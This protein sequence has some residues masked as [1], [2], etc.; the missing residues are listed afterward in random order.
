MA[1]GKAQARKIIATNRRARYDYHLGERLEAGLQLEGWEAKSLRAG[2]VQL[3]DGHVRILR[4]EAFLLGARIQP[5]QSA[6][7]HVSADPERTRRLLLH[8]R[9][10]NHLA[11]AVMRKGQALIPTLL[12]WKDGR[13]KLEIALATGKKTHDKRAAIQERDWKRQQQRLLKQRSR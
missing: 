7:S 11:G 6:S 10:I 3:R 13:A 2:Q 1:A 4:G 5:L 8:R 12:Y 9:E